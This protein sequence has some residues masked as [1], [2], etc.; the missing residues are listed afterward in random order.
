[1]FSV[2]QRHH[3]QYVELCNL[4]SLV[5]F[6]VTGPRVLTSS[7]TQHDCSLR[8]LR[9]RIEEFDSWIHDN[10]TGDKYAAQ[11]MFPVHR[12]SFASNVVPSWL[13]TEASTY[14][15][16]EYKRK[17]RVRAQWTESTKGEG[18]KGKD[19]GKKGTSGKGPESPQS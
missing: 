4:T 13:V 19:K 9:N 8:H 3:P 11:S 2:D 16:S 6:K 15:Q 1:M 17:E 10:R 14:S 18:K 7:T 12:S 5:D